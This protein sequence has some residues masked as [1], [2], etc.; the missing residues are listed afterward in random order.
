[1]KK[2]LTNY[3]RKNLEMVQ[4]KLEKNIGTLTSTPQKNLD[5]VTISQEKIF[6]KLDEKFNFK[7][8]L[9]FL[10]SGS[11]DTT[12]YNSILK[13]LSHSKPHKKSYTEYS[14]KVSYLYPDNGIGRFKACILKRVKDISGNYIDMPVTCSTQTSMWNELKS[15][16]LN[17]LYYDVDIVNCQPSILE[18]IMI[19]NKLDTKY[20][21]IYNT[22]RESYFKEMMDTFNYDRKEAKTLI[23]SIMFGGRIDNEIYDKLPENVKNSIYFYLIVK[24]NHHEIV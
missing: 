17:D 2:I 1:M 3:V 10:L 13:Y 9:E 15:Y 7:K 8:C 14:C 6:V 21:N 20:I 22:N 19:K 11:L 12:Y 24:P 5:S 23:I 4:T 16:I 18:H